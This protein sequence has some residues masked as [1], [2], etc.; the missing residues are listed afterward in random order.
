MFD[1]RK[2]AEALIDRF[3]AKILGSARIINSCE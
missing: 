1:E 2:I 3:S